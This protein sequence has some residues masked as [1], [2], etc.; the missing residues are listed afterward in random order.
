MSRDLYLQSLMYKAS[1]RSRLWDKKYAFQY[2]RFPIAQGTEA[3]SYTVTSK[4]R[5]DRY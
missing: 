4:G 5:I 3:D 1:R 2:D